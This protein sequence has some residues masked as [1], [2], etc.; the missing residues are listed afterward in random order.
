VTWPG[1]KGERTAQA[2]LRNGARVIVRRPF[3]FPLCGTVVR[4][5]ES[6]QEVEVRLVIGRRLQVFPMAWVEV[7][8]EKRRTA[9]T[10]SHGPESTAWEQVK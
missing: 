6:S 8:A 3:T 5:V 1:A 7:R 9:K 2:G 10:E 4:V